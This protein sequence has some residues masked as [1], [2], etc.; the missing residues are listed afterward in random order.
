MPRPPAEPARSARDGRRHAACS[1]SNVNCMCIAASG[2][3]LVRSHG[4]AAC[5]LTSDP[6]GRPH[7]CGRTF[8][9]PTTPRNASLPGWVRAPRCCGFMARGTDSHGA[10]F[11]LAAPQ[12][13]RSGATTLSLHPPCQFAHS[14]LHTRAATRGR[15]VC[16]LAI[17]LSRR[18]WRRFSHA[19]P[20]PERVRRTSESTSRQLQCRT[21]LS[22]HYSSATVAPLIRRFASARSRLRRRRSHPGILQKRCS[23]GMRSRPH[24][25]TAVTSVANRESLLRTR[26][27][28][29]RTG[30]P[31]RRASCGG[32]AS[33]REAHIHPPMSLPQPIYPTNVAICLGIDVRFGRCIM[34]QHACFS[35]GEC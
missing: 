7:F 1:R 20:A 23:W 2:A 35:H 8:P 34:T 30:R 25:S 31:R 19:P 32:E 33:L 17:P 14:P 21:V 10:G 27:G 9:P 26:R 16:E 28:N 5:S 22:A 24:V 15:R 18:S 13:E 3:P 4:C 6:L 12:G 11:H 29:R